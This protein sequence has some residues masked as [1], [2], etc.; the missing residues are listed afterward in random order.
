L[1]TGPT[2][3]ISSCICFIASR[4]V[5]FELQHCE[6][7]LLKISLIGGHAGKDIR[8]AI[9]S[10]MDNSVRIKEIG[11]NGSKIIDGK[12]A[13]RVVSKIYSHIN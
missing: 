2:L 9:E 1:K 10:L 3:S 13:E 8:D 4:G 6:R 12:G 11:I 5:N 7:L